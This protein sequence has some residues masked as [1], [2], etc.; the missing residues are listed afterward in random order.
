MILSNGHTPP[1][2]R[3]KID[4][5]TIPTASPL[6][7]CNA[8]KPSSGAPAGST[9]VHSSDGEP[10]ASRLATGTLDLAS[11]RREG[12]SQ[13]TIIPPPSTKAVHLVSQ[14]TIISWIVTAARPGQSTIWPLVPELPAGY[15]TTCWSST[16][17]TLPSAVVAAGLAENNR[18]GLHRTSSAG[19]GSAAAGVDSSPGITLLLSGCNTMLPPHQA[20]AISQ[21]PRMMQD[22]IRNS[23]HGSSAV[24]CTV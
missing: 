8:P 7:P 11:A 23:F 10:R 1:A 3:A 19:A 20:V 24:S 12:S 4:G 14:V 13:G 15:T 2:A 6:H 22:S 16:T 17:T 18:E 21:T 5:H 9:P